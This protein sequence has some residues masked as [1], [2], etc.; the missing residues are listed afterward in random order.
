MEFLPV[1]ETTMETQTITL[2]P[3]DLQTVG[4]LD[5]TLTIQPD[6]DYTVASGSNATVTIYGSGSGESG[7][8]RTYGGPG[9]TRRGRL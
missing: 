5:A 3:V 2:T 4:T 7:F 1:I 8:R 6:E 9:A